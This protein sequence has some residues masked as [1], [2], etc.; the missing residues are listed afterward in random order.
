[1][2]YHIHSVFVFA[3]C[4]LFFASNS[5]GAEKTIKFPSAF[6][7]TLKYEF[8]PVVEG[9]PLKHDFIIQNRGSA[10]LKILKVKPGCGCATVFFSKEVPPGGEGKITVKINT[11]GYGGRML[12]KKIFVETNDHGFFLTVIGNVNRFATVIPSSV[13]LYGLEGKQITATVTIIPD[14]KYLFKIVGVSAKNGKNINF[15]LEETKDTKGTRY[16]LSIE[17]MKKKKGRYKDIVFL[18]TDSKIR[19]EIKISIHGNITEGTRKK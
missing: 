19:P 4:I 5:S 17:N 10:P 13:K 8:P 3:L 9:L 12:K 1:M 2:R 11:T 6:L 7:P 18:K 14:K 15:R 16:L